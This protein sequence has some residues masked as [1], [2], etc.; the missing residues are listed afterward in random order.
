MDR[1]LKSHQVTQRCHFCCCLRGT[2]GTPL[3]LVG[4]M[5]ANLASMLAKGDDSREILAVTLVRVWPV[6]L[7]AAPVVGNAHTAGPIAANWQKQSSFVI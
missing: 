2:L 4:G 5:A 1:G 7:A 6:R 3:G